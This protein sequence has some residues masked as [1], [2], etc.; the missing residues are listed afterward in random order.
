M[1]STPGDSGRSTARKGRRTN[2]PQ[3]PG[4]GVRLNGDRCAAAARH[5]AA[6]PPRQ[7]ST[8]ALQTPSQAVAQLRSGVLAFLA[9]QPEAQSGAFK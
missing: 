7:E 5:M 3:Y 6:W 9:S 2:Q 1:S 8:N 4:A